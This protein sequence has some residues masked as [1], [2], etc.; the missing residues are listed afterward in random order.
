MPSTMG[1]SKSGKNTARWGAALTCALAL[2]FGLAFATPS[3]AQDKIYVESNDPSGNA[4]LAYTSDSS[5]NLTLI[6]SY[7]TG[8]NGSY[9]LQFGPYD[10]DNPVIVNSSHTLL[11]AVNSGSNSVSV[12]DINGDGTLMAVD[13]SPFSSGGTY[14]VSLALAPN[15]KSLIVV[16]KSTQEPT[17]PVPFGGTVPPNYAVFT[18]SRSGALSP[19]PASTL[20]IAYDSSP[21]QALFTG[22]GSLAFGDD[23][24]GGLLRSFKISHSGALTPLQ[25]FALPASQFTGGAPRWPL[26]MAVNS[27]DNLLYVGLPTIGKLDTF[28]YTLGGQLTFVNSA[29][30]TGAAI[31]WVALNPAAPYLYTTNNVDA[32]V[33]TYSL[34]NPY[35]PS[36]IQHL[37]LDLPT[38]SSPFQLQVDPSGSFLYVIG[39]SVTTVAPPPA[40][41][42]PTIG[43]NVIHVLSIDST[44]GNVTEVNT[45]TLPV[46]SNIRP[47]GMV[48]F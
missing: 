8:G 28:S 45:V 44:T 20:T 14:P 4:I 7:A 12:F 24:V 23:F 37:V 18:V 47:Q 5:G 33:S 42:G 19:A 11:F 32:S 16:N 30:N 40:D 21:S 26:G 39:Q 6:G 9:S 34:A 15:G 46:D 17:T 1:S 43:G 25:T 10:N 35:A 36:E 38:T 41:A 22:Q 13:G 27:A 29:V 31:C 3:R 2:C 48:V